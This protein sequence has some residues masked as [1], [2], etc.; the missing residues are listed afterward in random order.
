MRTY[1]PK[2]RRKA[3]GLDGDD[4][5]GILPSQMAGRYQLSPEAKLCI[6]ALDDAIIRLVKAQRNA[7]RAGAEEEQ[8]WMMKDDWEWPFSFV[9][10][11]AVIGLEPS[12]VRA[13]VRSR[14]PQIHRISVDSGRRGPQRKIA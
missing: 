10:L 5:D 6:A 13:A 3:W 7:A 14:T 11:C 2:R 1:K 9:N 4:L 8:R 12:A